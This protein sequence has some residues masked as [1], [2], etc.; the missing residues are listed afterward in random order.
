[1]SF[2]FETL[3]GFR[4]FYM[5][6]KYDNLADIYSVCGLGCYDSS[7]VST[8]PLPKCCFLGELKRLTDAWIVDGRV[9]H[10]TIIHYDTKAIGF[11]FCR[12]SRH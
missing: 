9:K 7:E 11:S 5:W 10:P 3:G 4:V 6:E 12:M 1:M 8:F 2:L